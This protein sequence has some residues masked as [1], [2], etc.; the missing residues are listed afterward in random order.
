MR[1]VNKHKYTPVNV[2]NRI[3]YLI[4]KT[5]IIFIFKKMLKNK[6]N[7]IKISKDMHSKEEKHDISR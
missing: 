6:N 5:I 3:F 4:V 1:K 2:H 7:Y